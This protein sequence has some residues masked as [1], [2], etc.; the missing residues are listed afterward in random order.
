MS[1]FVHFVDLTLCCVLDCSLTP[2]DNDLFLGNL[3]DKPV[4]AL[5]G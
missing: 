4:L 3:V 1:R 2:D 5:N